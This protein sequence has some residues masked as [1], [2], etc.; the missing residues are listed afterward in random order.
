MNQWVKTFQPQAQDIESITITLEITDCTG[1]VY[2][3]DIMFQGGDLATSWV[4]HPS[5]IRWSFDNV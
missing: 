4:G 2:I 5:E 1:D 3:T